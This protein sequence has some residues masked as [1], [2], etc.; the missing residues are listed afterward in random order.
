MPTP[1]SDFSH[2]DL[3]V[4]LGSTERRNAIL[5]AFRLANPGSVIDAL[6]FDLLDLDRETIL[7]Y[8]RRSREAGAMTVL[9]VPAVAQPGL[10]LEDLPEAV[11]DADLILALSEGEIVVIKSAHGATGAFA[12]PEEI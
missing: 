9:M 1:Y 5:R 12:W 2:R 10:A 11:E 7:G 3:G 8:K 6:A 4:L